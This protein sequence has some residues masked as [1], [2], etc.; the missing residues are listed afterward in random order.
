[1]KPSLLL[2]GYL[3]ATCCLTACDSSNNVESS[4]NITAIDTTSSVQVAKETLGQKL[5]F[6]TNLSAPAGLACASC[7]NPTN[8]FTDPDKQF[9]TSEGAV[10]ERFDER[11]TPSI[12][13]TS[14]SPTFHWDEALQEYRGG[15]FW[16]GRAST[17]AIQAQGP[18]LEPLEMANPDPVSVVNKVKAAEYATLMQQVY[19]A[20]IFTNVAQA[21]VSIG[22]AI[23]A[24]E[25]TKRFHPF[26]SKYDSYL[27]GKITLTPQEAQG[28]RLF[29]DTTKGNC[30]TCHP[31]TPSADGTPPL[32][33]TFGYANI[34]LPQ[35]PQIALAIDQ[36]ASDNKDYGLGARIDLQGDQ[37]GKF[38]I[39]TL[40]NIANTA[41][42][43]HNGIFTDL[44]EMIAFH[45]LRDTPLNRWA[46]AEV[47]VNVD[48][49]V[50]NLGL[51]DSEVAAIV[52][53]L[54]TLS[55]GYTPTN[56]KPLT[57]ETP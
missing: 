35:N 53:F 5:F 55:D 57:P 37:R 24:F 12:A 8:A 2:T 51:S 33:T 13:Y 4:P 36:D 30:I 32:F 19:G 42:Y 10:A 52:A 38:K 11:H 27:A 48:K 14:F 6:D 15:Q 25:Q 46:A 45:N 1:M 43:G 50:G 29:N 17:Q 26:D 9:P 47:G 7:H 28:L 3:A 23:A 44:N 49:R 54:Q 39:P 56:A 41:P 22:D 21:Y 34:G 31:S 20:D 16:D 40:R 18:L